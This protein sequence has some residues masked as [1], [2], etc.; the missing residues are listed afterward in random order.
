MKNIKIPKPITK[1]EYKTIIAIFHFS[2]SLN[3]PTKKI[4]VGII[5]STN[6]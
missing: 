4:T 3:K 2:G 1:S 6:I 5:K